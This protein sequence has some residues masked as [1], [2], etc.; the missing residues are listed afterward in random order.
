MHCF[1]GICYVAVHETEK[2]VCHFLPLI[3]ALHEA[4]SLASISTK[5]ARHPLGALKQTSWA[6]VLGALALYNLHTANLNI[7]YLH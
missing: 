4:S 6:N 3:L 5:N 7:H 2:N 1:I